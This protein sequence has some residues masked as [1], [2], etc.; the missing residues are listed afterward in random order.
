MKRFLI[1]V[2][3]F[4]LLMSALVSCQ[5]DTT[6]PTPDEK[7]ADSE[8]AKTPEEKEESTPSTPASKPAEKD[9]T[10][11]IILSPDIHYTRKL[12]WSGLTSE[13]RAQMWVDAIIA[14][15]EEEPIDLVVLMGDISLDHWMHGGNWLEDEES[16]AEIFIWEQAIAKLPKEIEVFALPGNHE[17]FGYDEWEIMMGNER[18]DYRVMGDHLILLLDNFADGLNPEEDHDGVYTGVDMEY[19]NEIVAQYPDKY[20]W[21]VTHFTHLPFESEAFKEFLRTNTNVKAIFHGHNH[22]LDV[23]DLGEEY[24]NVK[25]IM[26]GQFSYTGSQAPLDQYYSFRDLHLDRYGGV[27]NYII[28]EVD[29]IVNGEPV[30]YQKVEDVDFY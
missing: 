23:E 30:E 16:D 15:H 22:T 10:Y 26:C 9:K 12:Q 7:P 2:C 3:V 24:N 19:V 29:L 14:E 13:E 5:K 1:F 4:A 27:C 6:D 17:Q 18:Q 20:I 11:R 28:P 25:L 21:I 8:T